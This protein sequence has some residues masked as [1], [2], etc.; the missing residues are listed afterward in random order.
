VVNQEATRPLAEG[1]RGKIW[2]LSIN[3]S[4]VRV[5]DQREAASGSGLP[6]KLA[7]WGSPRDER[8][9][10]RMESKWDANTRP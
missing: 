4:E 5:M 1:E 3:G 9:L 2:S 8:L 6:W 10:R 7:M